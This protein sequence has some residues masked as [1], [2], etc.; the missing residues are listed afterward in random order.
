MV[1]TVRATD[2]LA[3][4]VLRRTYVS[5]SHQG[6]NESPYAMILPFPG[7]RDGRCKALR[8]SLHAR[9]FCPVPSVDVGTVTAP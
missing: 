8:A 9:T 3:G 1:G 6:L 7:R 2:P 4:P 5:T